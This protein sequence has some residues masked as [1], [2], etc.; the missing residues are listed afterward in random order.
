MNNKIGPFLKKFQNVRAVSN[1]RNIDRIIRCYGCGKVGHYSCDCIQ[2]RFNQYNYKN[3][4]N[5]N[6]HSNI[7][8]INGSV[9]SDSYSDHDELIYQS[10]LVNE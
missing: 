1:S 3:Q 7:F 10:V 2:K 9:S 8:H 4:Q 6:V 5:R